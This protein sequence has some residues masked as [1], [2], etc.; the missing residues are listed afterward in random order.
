MR[1]FPVAAV[2]GMR[3]CGV[4]GVL[5]AV[6]LAVAGL[7]GGIHAGGKEPSNTKVTAKAGAIGKDGLQTVTVT[8]EIAAPWYAYANPVG[9]EDL[10]SA[11]TKIIITSANKLQDVKV[12][13]PAGKAKSLGDIKYHAYEGKVDITAQVIRAPGDTGPLD[14]TVKYMNCNPKGICLPPEEVKLQLK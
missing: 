11:R 14:V 12:N 8:M 3:L 5:A 1:R 6:A 7:P 13:Y 10:E 2:R 4:A 9:N